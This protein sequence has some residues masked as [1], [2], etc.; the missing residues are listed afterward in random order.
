MDVY[1]T[2]LE[3]STY[4]IPVF[5]LLGIYFFIRFLIYEF[6]SKTIIIISSAGI[7]ILLTFLFGLSKL[8]WGASAPLAFILLWMSFFS[9]DKKKSIIMIALGVTFYMFPLLIMFC[10]FNSMGWAFEH[11][12]HDTKPHI[13]AIYAII[14]Y[15]TVIWFPV[16]I[17]CT[18]INMKAR[19]EKENEPHEEVII[20]L[21]NME[22]EEEL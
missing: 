19:E 8:I 20:S 12:P 15:L 5:V 11:S 22:S 2:I 21:S 1:K 16:F 13:V 14:V 7:L 9:Y 17:K 3:T 18:Y 6:P 10:F 4:S